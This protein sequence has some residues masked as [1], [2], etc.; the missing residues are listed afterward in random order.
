MS[1]VRRTVV[2]AL[3]RRPDRGGDRVL[4][5]RR[6]TPPDLAGRWEFPGGK[7]EAGEDAR[8]A[9][10]REIAEELGVEVSLGR[11]LTDHGRAWPI[12]AT[13]ALRL[14]AASPVGGDPEPGADHDEVRW[15]T[16]GELEATPLDWLEADRRALPA[17]RDW[18]GLAED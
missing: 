12:S 7:V 10:V 13:H 11:E 2:G 18:L 1:A 8:S 3:V 16:A 4:V 5:A 9:L 6:T 15:L 14:F 17:V